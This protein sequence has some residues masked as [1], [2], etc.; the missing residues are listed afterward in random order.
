MTSRKARSRSSWG[1]RRPRRAATCSS[2]GAGA[3][4]PG[5]GPVPDAAVKRGAPGRGQHPPRLPA[6]LRPAWLNVPQLAAGALAARVLR[7]P[8]EGLVSPLARGGVPTGSSLWPIGRLSRPLRAQLNRDLRPRGS[9]RTPLSSMGAA[10]LWSCPGM[11]RPLALGRRHWGS[12]S[13][14]TSE[15]RICWRCAVPRVS[16]LG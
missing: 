13:P 9:I 2:A 5:V 12:G 16:L 7:L 8:D 11:V 1:T 10:A 3:L 4:H 14:V 15:D 6:A